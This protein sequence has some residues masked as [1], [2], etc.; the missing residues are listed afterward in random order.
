MASCEAYK[1]R[2]SQKVMSDII[3]KHDHKHRLLAQDESRNEDRA[4]YVA[5]RETIIL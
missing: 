4:L 1:I 5:W 3:E 2:S